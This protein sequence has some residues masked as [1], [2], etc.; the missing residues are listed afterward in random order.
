MIKFVTII[1]NVQLHLLN[2]KSF[3]AIYTDQGPGHSEVTTLNSPH[4]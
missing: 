4:A 1:Q 2:L 3:G